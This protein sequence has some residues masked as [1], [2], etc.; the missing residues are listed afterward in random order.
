[1]KNRKKDHD[2]WLDVIIDSYLIN[3][4]IVATIIILLLVI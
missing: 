1:M 2:S 3:F 4:V